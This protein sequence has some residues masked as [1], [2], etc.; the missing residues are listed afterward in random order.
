MRVRVVFDFGTGNTYAGLFIKRHD[1]LIQKIGSYFGIVV[2]DEEVFAF[3]LAHAPII[4]AGE[5]KIFPASQDSCVGII[6]PFDLV[7]GIDVGGHV[8]NEDLVIGV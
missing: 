2:Y 5:S 6:S 4:T 1:E 3:C 7:G 8:A